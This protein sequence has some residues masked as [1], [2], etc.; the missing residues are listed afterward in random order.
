MGEKF[1]IP[2]IGVKKKKPGIR[3]LFRA[4]KKLLAQTLVPFLKRN[5]KIIIPGI[6]LL[7]LVALGVYNFQINQRLSR[8]EQIIGHPELECDPREVVERVSR[9]VVRIIGNYS[10]GSGFFIDDNLI[11]TNFHVVAD[12]PTPKVVFAD[13]IFVQGQVVAADKKA[14]IAFVEVAIPL[15]IYPVLNRGYSDRLLPLEDLIAIGYPYGTGLQGEPT[16]LQGRFI[17]RR[18]DN[19]A[20]TELLQIDASVIKGMSGGPLVNAC[21]EVVGVTTYGA[22]GFGGAIPIE[23]FWDLGWQ[24]LV[25]E[26]PTAGIEWLEFKPNESPLECVKAFYNY[27]T[28]GRLDKA[29]ELLSRDYTSWTFDEWK[30]GYTTTFYIDLFFTKVIDEETVFIRFGAG[31]LINE[32][33]VY[34][35]FEGTQKVREYD[36]QLKLYES[37]VYEV[38]P[39]GWYWFYGRDL[40]RWE[41]EEG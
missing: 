12:N 37:N 15:N 36:G 40:E 28:I 2:K 39:T 6:T 17:S 18:R 30:E 34:R 22:A 1:S 31:D 8:L 10:E 5:V 14:D 19:Q 38:K 23:Q 13:Y 35:F 32:E 3:G 24:A 4:G 16:F 26:E 33:I 20:P 41:Q 9:S 7:A 11:A 27:Q 29:Y 21:G 25:S